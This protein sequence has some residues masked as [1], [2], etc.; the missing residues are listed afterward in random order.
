[1]YKFQLYKQLWCHTFMLTTEELEVSYHF[2]K[3]Y[4]SEAELKHQH[5]MLKYAQVP[6]AS[7]FLTQWHSQDTPLLLGSVYKTRSSSSLSSVWTV[8]SSAFL[9]SQFDSQE[10]HMSVHFKLCMNSA[11]W[12]NF[13]YNCTSPVLGQPWVQGEG[14]VGITCSHSLSWLHPWDVWVWR[15]TFLPH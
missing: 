9:F 6:L 3:F 7:V 12:C 1:M 8:T 13:L 11:K 10:V 4:A 14:V 5:S 15:T 2:A